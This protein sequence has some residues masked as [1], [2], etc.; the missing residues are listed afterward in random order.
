MPRDE[1]LKLFEAAIVEICNFSPAE[2]FCDCFAVIENKEE[3]ATALFNSRLLYY[4]IDNNMT[5]IY[6]T[7]IEA[8]KFMKNN[9][10]PF[11]RHPMELLPPQCHCS[12]PKMLAL[13]HR[14]GANFNEYVEIN[15]KAANR[16]AGKQD[17]YEE[18]KKTF[19]KEFHARKNAHK[20]VITVPQPVSMAQVRHFY[21]TIQQLQEDEYTVAQYLIFSNSRYGN[22]D[23][24]Y[25]LIKIGADLSLVSK[26]LKHNILHC[27]IG[28]VT[29]NLVKYLSENSS[30]LSDSRMKFI[31]QDNAKL[32]ELLMQEN[33]LKIMPVT[34]L[35][36]L[37][38]KSND[39][40]SIIETMF[41]N[42]WKMQV[43]FYSSN[44]ESKIVSQTM[45]EHT[46]DYIKFGKLQNVMHSMNLSLIPSPFESLNS[47]ENEQVSVAS[48]K[49]TILHYMSNFE[50]SSLTA[51]M[52]LLQLLIKKNKPF[53][54]QCL[55]HEAMFNGKIHTM[56]SLWFER[57][58]LSA[59]MFAL[60]HNFYGCRLPKGTTI[61]AFIPENMGLYGLQYIIP[62]CN[63]GDFI[64]NEKQERAATP[65][66]MY[67]QPL[68]TQDSVLNYLANNSMKFL[69][70]EPETLFSIIAKHDKNA[71][72]LVQA[73][74]ERSK[75]FIP[76]MFRNPLV[77]YELLQ[78]LTN[79]ADKKQFALM[80]AM[81]NEARTTTGIHELVASDLCTQADLVI[82]IEEF[83]QAM[84]QDEFRTKVLPLKNAKKLT[85]IELVTELNR[86][87]VLKTLQQLAGNSTSSAP[88]KLGRDKDELASDETTASKKKQKKK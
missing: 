35:M 55:N 16:Y 43:T 26:Q 53:V 62:D 69:K 13:L 8:M 76:S 67:N 66:R 56:L 46:M 42:I 48:N 51:V 23:L 74:Q 64:L 11:T 30:N 70:H 17:E 86:K 49:P 85:C 9:M 31:L 45:F 88:K 28:N 36:L 77:V 33:S 57:E 84:G 81:S 39:I 50:E 52:N 41:P 5:D 19:R 72:P 12:T 21:Q 80:I 24:L 61:E 78:H 4:V 75:M 38:E 47:A 37:Y 60:L 3:L 63:N 40:Y 68:I 82:I 10:S 27:L 32:K 83:A 65:T 73:I 34:S 79:A 1:F 29:S 7:L 59:D 44:D 18:A 87:T 54:E 22:C 14:F 6:I 58:R 71:K 20:D 15:H 25:E 2:S